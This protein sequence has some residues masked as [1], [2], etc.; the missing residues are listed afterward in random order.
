MK[1]ISGFAAFAAMHALCMEANGEAVSNL[2]SSQDSAGLSQPL[3]GDPLVFEPLSLTTNTAHA[4]PIVWVSQTGRSNKVDVSQSGETFAAT[5]SILQSGNHLTAHILQEGSESHIDI[6][7]Y[8]ENNLLALTQSGVGNLLQ[9]E[10]I[11]QGLSLEINQ[12][13][14]SAVIVKQWNY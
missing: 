7:Q 4:A 11:G 10:Q 14:G 5:A 13:G 2:A 1:S 6:E 8:G 9:A 3:D 12:S